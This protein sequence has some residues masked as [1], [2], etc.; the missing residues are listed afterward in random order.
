MKVP[1]ALVDVDT[2]RGRSY[3]AAMELARRYACA[4]RNWVVERVRRIIGG[5]V[6][7]YT[8]NHH[9]FVWL[10]EH[11]GRKL[12]VVR[13]GATPRFQGRKALLAAL[14]ATMRWL[15]R[16]PE[17]RKPARRFFPR[18]TA[19]AACLAA[20]TPASA[21]PRPNRCVAPRAR[22]DTDRRRS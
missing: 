12:W 11:G 21:R 22:R 10:E 8:H 20:K 18:F 5:A 19:P 7:R 1:P 6:T 3:L 9:N 17:A 15:W 13:K 14:W 16:A 2:D 4:G